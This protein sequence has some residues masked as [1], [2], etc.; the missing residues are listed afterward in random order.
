M[1]NAQIMVAKIIWDTALY[2]AVPALLYFHDLYRR[3]VDR[4]TLIFGLAQ[5]SALNEHIQAF[6]RDWL[7]LSTSEDADAFIGYYDVDFMSR[8]HLGLTTDLA[9]AAL[10]QQYRR[11]IR[12]LEQ[13]AGQLVSVVLDQ[14][15]HTS[16][17]PAAQRQIRAWQADPFLTNLPAIYQQDSQTNPL[18]SSWITLG[19]Q[20]AFQEK[21]E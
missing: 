9:D 7:A 17:D 10:E 3:I 19:R 8:L 12:F 2:W 13:L 4:P 6:F 21:A 20:L 18:N 14:V 16:P 15:V 1:G 5:M 11:N